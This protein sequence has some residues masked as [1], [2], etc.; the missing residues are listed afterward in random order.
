M[1]ELRADEAEEMALA[2][3]CGVE[4]GT[5]DWDAWLTAYRGTLRWH[6]ISA[7]LPIEDLD[8]RNEVA[9]RRV[10]RETMDYDLP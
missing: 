4:R 10:F 5:A 6:W 8:A 2:E 9:L 7:G 3:E 1:K